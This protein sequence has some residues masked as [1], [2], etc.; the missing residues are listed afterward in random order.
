MMT[1]PAGV[2][3]IRLSRGRRPRVSR[4]VDAKRISREDSI[5]DWLA[6]A[7]NQTNGRG[8]SVDA[9]RENPRRSFRLASRHAVA[10]KL[11]K[12][13][14]IYHVSHMQSR[15][16]VH[17][18]RT[19]NGRH[20]VDLVVDKDDR[21]VLAIEVTLSPEGTDND[22]RH[23]RRLREQIV[24]PPL[25]SHLAPVGTSA[26]R[27]ARHHWRRDTLLEGTT[28]RHLHDRTWSLSHSIAR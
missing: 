18:L 9:V 4:G 28:L 25:T 27:P 22:V 24:R 5:S 2:G 12:P 10:T 8:M 19:Y 11:R 23:L 6:R 14:A 1:T 7:I 26:P 20:E 15:S 21:C 13:R 17:H 16:R 3:N